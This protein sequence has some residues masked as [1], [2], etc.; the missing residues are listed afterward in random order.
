MKLKQE[1]KICFHFFCFVAQIWIFG[2]A[3]D[4][5]LGHRT[6]SH[7]IPNKSLGMELL[8]VNAPHEHRHEVPNPKSSS[9]QQRLISF[10]TQRG[11]ALY[12]T[13]TS[14]VLSL[15]RITRE[16]SDCY[17]ITL[18]AACCYDLSKVFGSIQTPC[19]EFINFKSCSLRIKFIWYDCVVERKQEWAMSSSIR[20][21]RMPSAK[22]P[23][24]SAFQSTRGLTGVQVSEAEA[25]AIL[26]QLANTDENSKKTWS[27]LFVEKYLSN[28]SSDQWKTFVESLSSFSLVLCTNS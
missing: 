19:F 6:F 16:K 17:F 28:V 15:R 14:V 22:T 21:R 13:G 3:G 9:T 8:T 25:D 7:S 20:R 26:E 24:H 4:C 10:N 11:I 5:A 2:P 27:R 1:L 18:S 23:S 12:N